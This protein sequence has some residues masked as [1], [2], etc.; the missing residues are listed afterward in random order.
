[1]KINIHAGPLAGFQA[2]LLERGDSSSRVKVI[3]FE[4]QTIV[5]VPNDSFSMPGE[6]IDLFA[7]FAERIRADRRWELSDASGNWWLEQED[8]SARTWKEHLK[9][10]ETNERRVE[11]ETQALLER[12]KSG[13]SKEAEYEEIDNYFLEHQEIFLPHRVRFRNARENVSNAD[14]A[15]R[16]EECSRDVAKRHR[17]A[18][19]AWWNE[20]PCSTENCKAFLKAAWS[21]KDVSTL[22]AREHEAFDRWGRHAVELIVNRDR[23]VPLAVRA[24]TDLPDDHPWKRFSDLDA[25]AAVRANF[26]PI[27]MRIP[28]FVEA[29]AMVV[30]AIYVVDLD[31]KPY[32]LYA[33]DIEE[34]DGR[35]PSTHLSLLIGGPALDDAALKNIDLRVS[36]YVRSCNWSVPE[37]LRTFYRVHHGLGQLALWSNR[38]DNADSVYPV[39]QLGVV[40]EPM[41]KIARE[42]DFTPEG[43][44]FDDLLS[45]YEDGAGNSENFFRTESGKAPI[46]TVDWDHETREIGHVRSFWEFL[47]TSARKSWVGASV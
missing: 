11:E 10:A 5:D 43:Y 25:G 36:D 31:A 8:L 17:V 7:S 9:R 27:S 6:H 46:G 47:E 4:R 32:L 30:R 19:R 29:L 37:D 26:E 44:R 2:E 21:S 33:C 3:L 34:N 24:L 14:A 20:Q 41:N 1:M 23:E 16:H 38:F 13:V 42:Q 39:E 28:K 18:Y 35:K 40:G 45:F 12:L 15:R 22:V